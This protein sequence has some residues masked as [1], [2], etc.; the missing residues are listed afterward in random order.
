MTAGSF[1]GTT[2][3]DDGEWMFG[4]WQENGG[5]S[6]I[7]GVQLIREESSADAV[8]GGQEPSEP[9]QRLP[10]EKSHRSSQHDSTA[11]YVNCQ[12]FNKL[13]CLSAIFRPVYILL[14]FCN[15]R[16]SCNGAM[17]LAWL[18]GPIE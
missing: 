6:D 14:D 13:S 10:I 4:V 11:L 16:R 18:M 1:T 2:T 15:D 12:R 9:S 17:L 7:G 5:V 8:A 3:G